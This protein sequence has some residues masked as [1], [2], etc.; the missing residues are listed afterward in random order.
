M[1][2]VE[3]KKRE[4]EKTKEV[5]AIHAERVE[6][7]SGK[8]G[9]TSKLIEPREEEKEEEAGEGEKRK[10]KG[11]KEKKKGSKTN[12]GKE[13]KK[14]K[15]REEVEESDKEEESEEEEEDEEEQ[16]ATPIGARTPPK[17]NRM[18][19]WVN[20]SKKET[21]RRKEKK[22]REEKS[23]M[24][25]LSQATAAVL[26]Q[27]LLLNNNTTGTLVF[28][29]IKIM[30]RRRPSEKF[31][32]EDKKIDFEDQLAQFNRAIDLP[33]LPASYKV[34]ELPHWFGGLARVHI[35]KYLQRDD[36]EQ[37]LEEAIEKL[38]YEHGNKAT[39][40][41]EMVEEMLKGKEIESNNAVGMNMAIRKLKE[42]FLLAVKTE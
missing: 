4:L 6:R 30:E 20:E 10:E 18:R 21:E 24:E 32:G 35:S 34:A 12:K 29:G 13:R 39:M 1:V 7:A 28:E 16:N 23:V 14:E 9:L 31:T 5:T 11:G 25:E 2:A 15:R 8:S 22:T 26:R 41:E 38:R 19:K 36:H 17:K 27:Q 42:A 33:G 40:A 3:A 37:A